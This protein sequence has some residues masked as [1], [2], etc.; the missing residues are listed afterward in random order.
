MDYK[1][2]SD[3][4]HCEKCDYI[5]S[6]KSQFERH[7]LTP[8]HKMDYK[9][10]PKS[11]AAFKCGCGKEY[12]HRQGLWKHSKICDGNSELIYKE[13]NNTHVINQLVQQNIQLITQNQ[14]FKQLLVDQNNKILDLS[15]QKG[16]IINN[17]THN[18]TN[19]TTNNNFNLQFFLNVQ[20]KDAL[21]IM[22]FVHSLNLQMKDLEETGR[23]GYIDGISRIFIKGLKE[24]DLTKRP[25]H[26][27]DLKRETIYIK[28]KDEWEKENEEKEKLKNIIK[29]IANKNIKQIPQWQQENP[30]YKDIES[31]MNDEYMKIVINSMSGSNEEETNKNYNKIMS[32]VAKEVV[33]QKE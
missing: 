6:R 10:V 28:D 12:K 9:K 27:S 25:I 4:F 24:L 14:E 33:I 2:S 19:N 23:L 5:S 15:N 17:T 32:K 11:S 30:G 16:T 13:E 7:L 1:K 8:K 21:N 26:C 18:T 31:K 29:E 3:F 22:D 20:C